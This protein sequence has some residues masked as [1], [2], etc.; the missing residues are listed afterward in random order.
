M[1]CV[2]QRDYSILH[3]LHF[4]INGFSV[5]WPEFYCATI[6]VR[7]Y[8]VCRPMDG[9]SVYILGVHWPDWAPLFIVMKYW[10]R[11][12]VPEMSFC[13]V[14]C[15]RH[16]RRRSLSRWSYKSAQASF[17]VMQFTNTCEHCFIYLDSPG[18]LE[19]FLEEK[20]RKGKV[21]RHSDPD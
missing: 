10:T 9:R 3:W 19:L 12:L 17:G 16:L 11:Q 20:W 21:H 7:H 4:S 18:V 2:V 6:V 8:A 1:L 13:V 15:E 5:Q 14:C